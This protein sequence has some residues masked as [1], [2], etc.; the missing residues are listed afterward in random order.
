M[1]ESKLQ[2]DF[3][4]MKQKN[5]DTGFVRSVRCAIRNDEGVYRVWEYIDSKRRWRSVDPTSIIALENA[6]RDGLGNVKIL[7]LGINFTADFESNLIRSDDGL[8]EYKIRSNVSNAEPSLSAKPV[9][10]VER[11]RA[12]KRIATRTDTPSLESKRKTKK[13]EDSKIDISGND[14]NDEEEINKPERTSN[15]ES[16]KSNDSDSITNKDM[17]KVILKGIAAVDPECRELI[18]TAHVYTESGDV[19]DALLNQTSAQHNN[20]KYFIM[21]L[22]ESDGSKQ[23]WVWFHWGRVGYKNVLKEGL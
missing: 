15:S 1:D 19:Y 12:T 22:L 5:L 18:D 23:Y 20:N 9:P 8:M 6:F 14:D 7:L 2:I 21:Q 10:R 16:Q 3:N 11:L 4:L 17:K 13:K